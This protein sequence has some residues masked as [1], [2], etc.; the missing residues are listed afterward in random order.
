MGIALDGKKDALLKA[1]MN[2]QFALFYHVWSPADSTVCRFVVDE[3]LKRIFRSGLPNAADI[4][5][6]VSGAN[7]KPLSDYIGLYEWVTVKKSTNDETS[8]EGLTLEPL[9][10]YCCENRDLRGVG[11]V[12][13][14]GVRILSANGDDKT[15]KAVNSWRHFLEWGVIDRWRDAIIRLVDYDTVGVNFRSQPWPHFG[16]NFWWAKPDYI[17]SLIRP[18]RG[19]FPEGH[20]SWVVQTGEERRRVTE[21]VD[22]ERWVGLNNPKAFS[23]Y[24][25][26]FNAAGMELPASFHDLYQNDIE[27][28]YRANSI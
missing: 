23:F 3:Q 16:G 6:Y 20:Y 26:P 11:Y 18:V 19:T 15:F 28:Y 1:P 17:R 21:R 24:G 22:F 2:K 25:F 27:P 7:P 12:H 10:D 8:Y 4:I 14:K 9:H 5:C 13:T